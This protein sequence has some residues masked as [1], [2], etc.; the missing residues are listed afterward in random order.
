MHA[1][2]LVPVASSRPP[3]MRACAPPL[4]QDRERGQDREQGFMSTTLPLLCGE[5]I[6]VNPRAPKATVVFSGLLAGGAPDLPKACKLE[7]KL[8]AHLSRIAHPVT[9]HN[10]HQG[11]RK[12]ANNEG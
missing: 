5:R 4:G 12:I 7:T 11:A 8:S 1:G 2:F 10:V 9:E 3:G 6:A